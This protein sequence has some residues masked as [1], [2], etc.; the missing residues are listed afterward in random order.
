[1]SREV[2]EADLLRKLQQDVLSDA[3][4]D[5]CLEKLQTEIEKREPHCPGRWL[6]S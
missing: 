2:L 3:A 6:R 1:M 5:Y 4:V